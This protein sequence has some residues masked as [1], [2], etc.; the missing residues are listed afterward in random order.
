MRESRYD[1]LCAI[2]LGLGQLC[3]FTG[4]DTQQ[5]I[6]ESVM[7]SVH[8]RR[9]ETIDAH[10]GYYGIAVVFAVTNISNLAAPWALGI[11][12]SKYCL[13][14]G[15]MLFSLHIASFFFVHWIPFYITSGLLGLGHALFYTGHGGYTTEHSTKATIGRNS[16][17]TWALA[18][19]WSV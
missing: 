3:M 6:V 17:L 10:A 4:Y 15:S 7:H 12:G 13:L 1:L 16:A 18:T 9:P 11:L 14:L 19:S 8:D 5:T 2:L